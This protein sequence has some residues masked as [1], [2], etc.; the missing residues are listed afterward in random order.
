MS[1][2]KKSTKKM[3]TIKEIKDKLTATAD[4]P[5]DYIDQLRQDTRKGV[6]SALKQYDIR[7]RKQALLN[8]NYNMMQSYERAYRK[9]GRQYI[10]GID[11]VGRGPLAGPVVSAA[12]ILP[13]EPDLVGINDSKQLSE[14]ERNKW[15]EK[16]KEVALSISYS[17]VSPER[18]DSLNI[19]EATKVSMKEA[20]EGLSIQPDCL[21]IDAMRI[22]CPVTQEKIIKG[23][24]K[25]ISIAAASIIAKVTRDNIM[26]ELAVTYPGYGFERNAGYGTKDHLQGL[27]DFGVTPIHR[28]SF[29][30]VKDLL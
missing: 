22:D 13:E 29:R 21:L 8:E 14:A 7:L 16:I 19:Y 18:I 20:V 15:A 25:S 3:Q 28:R 26:K 5:V 2:Q 30:P 4:L 27:K 24:A 23:D 6:Q 11:E 17:V 1:D 9:K 10:A 12:V